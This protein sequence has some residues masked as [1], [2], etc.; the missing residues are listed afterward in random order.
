[1]SHSARGSKNKPVMLVVTDPAGFGLRANFADWL[2]QKRSPRSNPELTVSQLPSGTR[3][4]LVNYVL[5][6][7][8]APPT[9]DPGTM[10]TPQIIKTLGSTVSGHGPTHKIV[11]GCVLCRNGL[12]ARLPI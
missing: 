11:A 9:V 3:P 2:Q 5:A 8:V 4:A 6:S 1:M 12:A 7:N 10:F